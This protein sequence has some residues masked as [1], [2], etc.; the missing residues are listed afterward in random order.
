MTSAKAGHLPALS[1]PKGFI[2]H[3]LSLRKLRHGEQMR[4]D[5]KSGVVEGGYCHARE[6]V[7]YGQQPVAGAASPHGRGGRSQP[8]LPGWNADPAGAS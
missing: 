7:L 6:G 8:L 5:P 3:D 2:R 4:Q 1:L